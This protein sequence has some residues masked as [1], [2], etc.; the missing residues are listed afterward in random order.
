M[1]CPA[2]KL[3]VVLDILVLC[4]SLIKISFRIA[5]QGS[6]TVVYKLRICELFTV[7]A[8]EDYLMGYINTHK[9][10]IKNKVSLIEVI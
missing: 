7:Y 4:G 9:N 2:G 3:I 6:F 8:V 5:E 10:R 1:S